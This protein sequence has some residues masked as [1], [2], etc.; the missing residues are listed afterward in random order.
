MRAA[1]PVPPTPP[2]RRPRRRAVPP[3]RLGTRKSRWT[4]L[5]VVACCCILHDINDYFSGSP[6][7]FAEAAYAGVA[8][9]APRGESPCRLDRASDAPAVSYLVRKP[10]PPSQTGNG[11]NKEVGS[12]TPGGGGSGDGS[13]RY[14]DRLVKQFCA[15]SY[16]TANNARPWVND[17]VVGVVQVISSCE[18]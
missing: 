16:T 9:F 2:A 15:Q 17:A 6:H 1:V 10:P 18:P 5:L 14:N 3:T 4:P 8:G 13:E 7:A 11:S 12:S